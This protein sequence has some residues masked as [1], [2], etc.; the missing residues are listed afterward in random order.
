[1]SP[2]DAVDALSPEGRPTPP[3]VPGI[4]ATVPPADASGDAS[5]R[6]GAD[7]VR[8]SNGSRR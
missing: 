4:S 7:R 1:M 2:E 6:G 3:A 8:H 5:R